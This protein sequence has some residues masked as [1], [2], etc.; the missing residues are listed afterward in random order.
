MDAQDFKNTLNVIT[1]SIV[2]GIII[3]AELENKLSTCIHG[4]PLPKAPVNVFE[5]PSGATSI[6]PMDV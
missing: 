4:F 6:R 1:L 5:V 2:T 3:N